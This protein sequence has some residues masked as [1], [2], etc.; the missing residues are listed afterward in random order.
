M[1]CC[2]DATASPWIELGSNFLL[3]GKQR[4]G[5]HGLP[6]VFTLEYQLKSENSL[7]LCAAVDSDPFIHL[8]DSWSPHGI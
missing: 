4:G 6:C 8:R 1:L 5:T 2:S 7:I 3:P